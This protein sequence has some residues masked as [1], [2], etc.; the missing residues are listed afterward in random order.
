MK[1]RWEGDREEGG[2][3]YEEILEWDGEL[4]I[5]EEVVG[6]SSRSTLCACFHCHLQ[7]HEILHKNSRYHGSRNI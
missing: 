2:Q 4:L 7:V 3:M 1:R 6:Q 5:W